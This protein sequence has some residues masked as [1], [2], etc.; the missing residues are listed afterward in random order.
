MADFMENA[1][2][3]NIRK[4]TWDYEALKKILPIADAHP[5]KQLSKWYILISNPK[6]NKYING[7]LVSR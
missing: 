5:H 7:I 3:S 2:L 4:S 6:V 1:K